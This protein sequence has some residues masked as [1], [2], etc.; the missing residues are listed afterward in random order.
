[1]DGQLAA[2]LGAVVLEGPLRPDVDVALQQV[3]DVAVALK[4]PEQLLGDGVEPHLLGGDEGEPLCQVEANLAA[5][6]TSR[7]R[8][9]TI[10]LVYS[11]FEDIPQEVFV[12]CIRH[13]S[14]H[15]NEQGTPDLMRHYFN[16]K[17]NLQF[18][19]KDVEVIYRLCY[20]SSQE[21]NAPHRFTIQTQ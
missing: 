15:I 8:T 17:T 12:R 3:A 14:P 2:D 21:H 19:K 5:E 16:Y 13:Y 7:A 20:T 6:H 18:N 9:G 1:M 4:E 11:V 10:P